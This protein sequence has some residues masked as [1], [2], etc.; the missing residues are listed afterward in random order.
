MR[1][2]IAIPCLDMVHTDFVRALLGM[3]LGGEVQFTFAQ[4][5]LVYDGRNKLAGIAL[6]GGFDAVLWLD[7]DMSFGGDL[8]KKMLLHFEAGREMVTGLYFTRKAPI[9]PVIYRKLYFTREDPRFPTPHAEPVE[10]WPTDAVFPVYAC[11]F[12][13][14]M[15]ST[16]LIGR[17]RDRF[18][19]P[20]SPQSGWGEDLS[21][22]IR[23]HEVG[24]TI[25]C[26]SSIRLGHVGQYVYTEKDC[27]STVDRF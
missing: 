23:A 4:S 3:E 13:A 15:T 8:L 9:T 17:V 11:G 12:G 14:V 18:G 19:L 26:D 2:L 27:G 24:A 22:C 25:Y 1:T 16:A 20:F 21:F 7:S 6:D 5:S 10:K